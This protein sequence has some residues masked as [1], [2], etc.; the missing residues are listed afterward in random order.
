MYCFRSWSLPWC[1]FTETTNRGA[2]IGELEALKNE[3]AVVGPTHMAL[4]FS[5]YKGSSLTHS[6]TPYTDIITVT[7]ND[8]VSIQDLSHVTPR[9]SLVPPRQTLGSTEQCGV[10]RER[11]SVEE[12]NGKMLSFVFVVVVTFISLW[13][14]CQCHD[15][16]YTFTMHHRHS[17][18]VRKW[19]H[20]AAGIPPPPEKGTVEYYAELAD[21]DR[22][23]RGRKLSQIDAGLAF[24]D[25]N[26]TFRISSLGLY[27]FFSFTLLLSLL[28]KALFFK[29]LI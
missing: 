19:S 11:V 15:H 6:P 16:V 21:R 8:T 14:F 24:S 23:L 4:A 17:E 10:S 28:F 13:E 12:P 22:F 20:A 18:P 3:S 25:G 5:Y 29:N 27:L 26:S 2:A 7:K 1:I 9:S